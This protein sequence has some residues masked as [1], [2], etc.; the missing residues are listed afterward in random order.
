[1]EFY[2][3]ERRHQE[4]GKVPPNELYFEKRPHLSKHKNM[5]KVV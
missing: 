2:N 4:I 5:L 1:M 3:N